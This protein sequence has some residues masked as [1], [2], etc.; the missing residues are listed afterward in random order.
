MVVR[1]LGLLMMFVCTTLTARL[2][3][4]AEYGTYNTGLS[5][6][7]VLATLAPLGTDRVLVKHLSLNQS[8]EVAAPEIALTHWCTLLM[9]GVLLAGCLLGV[10]LFQRVGPHAWSQAASLAAILFVPLTLTYLRQWVAIP[11]VGTRRALMPEQILIPG[12]T[13][14]LLTGMAWRSTRPL[15]AS[16]ATL[17]VSVL[18]FVVWGGTTYRGVLRPLYLQAFHDRSTGAGGVVERVSAGLPFVF[19]AVGSIVCQR[20]IPLVVSASCSFSDTAYFSYAMLVAG[21][22]SLPLGIVGLTLIPRFARH[23]HNGRMEESRRLARNASTLIFLIAV[24]L[25]AGLLIT[26]PLIPMILGAQWRAVTT[27]LPALLLASLVDC[28]TGPTVPVMQTTGMERTYSCLFLVYIPVQLLLLYGLSQWAGV[29]GAAVA[30]LLG[31]C[32]WNLLVTTLIYRQ[33]SL[34][35]L[36]ARASLREGL[37]RMRR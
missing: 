3:G 2:L 10:V 13:L 14:F 32:L 31:R 5:L 8:P 6:A 9:S 36:P 24:V 29:Q 34:V 17:I 26:A 7:I 12:L 15:T 30:Y 16:T 23:Y 25:S 11:L 35:M 27:L 18:T 19:V 1:V 33:R 4:P 28:L 21:L 22:P 20:G 37:S